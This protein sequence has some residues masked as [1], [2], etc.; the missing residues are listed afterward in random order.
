MAHNSRRPP[1][2]GTGCVSPTL[3]PGQGRT[4][5]AVYALDGAQVRPSCRQPDGWTRWSL[6]RPL[7]GYLLR[8]RYLSD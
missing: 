6:L 5:V 1:V 8:L 3:G 4:L 7:K 2:K